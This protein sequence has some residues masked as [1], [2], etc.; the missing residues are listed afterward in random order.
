MK[1]PAKPVV[2][3]TAKRSISLGNVTLE[4]EGVHHRQKRP[5]KP[6]WTVIIRGGPAPI[7]WSMSAE[8]YALLEALM[9]EH[10]KELNR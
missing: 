1:G 6:R 10:D 8:E 5:D 2:I 9:A 4:R 7:K 3:D